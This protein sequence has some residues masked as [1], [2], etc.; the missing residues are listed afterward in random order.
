ML[1][2]FVSNSAGLETALLISDSNNQDDYIRMVTDACFVPPGGFIYD[3]A[4][5]ALN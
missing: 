5:E 4:V 2:Y 3:G 1:R